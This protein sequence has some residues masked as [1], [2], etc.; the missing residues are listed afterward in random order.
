MKADLIDIFIEESGDDVYIRLQGTLGFMQ[1]AAVR[2]KIEMLIGGPGKFWFLDLEKVRFVDDEYLQLFLTVL[3]RIKKKEGTL[4]LLFDN[5]ENIAYFSKFANI[6]EI[7]PSRD[8]YR[9]SGLLKQLK[10]VG[11]TYSKQTGLRLSPGISVFL[12][13]LL[14]G[15]FLT[16]FSI[17]QNQSEE[18]REQKAQRMELENQKHQMVQEIDELRSMI[19]PLRHLGLVVDSATSRSF[20]NISDWVTYL[21]MLESRRRG[22]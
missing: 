1:L 3:N 9:R 21:E 13:I 15:W 17:I 6:F 2:E 19:G 5:A 10:L 11:A 14:V 16:L 8:A 7:Y 22:N 12:L 18:I 4:V 20:E